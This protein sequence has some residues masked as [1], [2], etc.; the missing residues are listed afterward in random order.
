MYYSRREFLKTSGAAALSLGIPGLLKNCAAPAKRPNIVVIMADD[1]GYSDIG[2]YGG[3]IETPNIDSLA[4]NGM[5]FTQFY[6]AARC[7]PTRASLLTGLYPHQ[8]GMGGMVSTSNPPGP[9]QGYLNDQCVT[10]A[11]VLKDAGYT[12]L[13][14]GKWH[15]GEEQPHWPTDRGFDR[16]FGLISG[17]A[18]YFDISRAKR[19]DVTRTMALDGEEFTPP[20]EGFYMTDAFSDYAVEFLDEHGAG[21]DPFFLYLA[22]TAPHWPLHAWPEDIAKY[23]G[24]YMSGWEQLRA[25][26]YK[27]MVEM[28]II[29]QDWEL[30]P[31][32]SEIIPWDD[33]DDKALMDRKMAVYAAQVDSMDQGIGKVLGKID[34]LGKMD[35]TLIMFLSDNG[36]CHEENVSTIANEDFEVGTEESYTSYGR[37]WAN[38][39]N[40]PYR[41]YKHW[42]HEGGIATPLVVQWPE[43]ITTGGELTDEVGHIMDIMATCCDVAGAEYPAERNGQEIVPLQGKSLKPIFQGRDRDGYET[44]FWE[45]LGN[46]AVRQGRWKLVSRD[47]GEWELYDM[48]EDRSELTNL[49]NEQ[50]ERTEE[51]ALQF[52]T[53]AEQVGVRL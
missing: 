32:D 31:P 6:N 45:H 35:N 28:G 43:T 25:E 41:M 40:T 1:M 10:I 42:V 21:E 2:C 37:D 18:N 3:E 11:E 8:A 44:L 30:S 46:R 34:E 51:M 23:E 14:S 29:D 12:T 5:R 36:G 15:V 26:R 27:R 50:P 24:K 53:W 33:V 16:Y 9:Y 52:M 20:D 22:Y 48:V 38:A 19:P 49:A 13:M 7:C 17:A 4:E 39:S 47:R